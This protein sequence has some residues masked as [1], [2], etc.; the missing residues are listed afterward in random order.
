[1]REEGGR[2]DSDEP[3]SPTRAACRFASSGET[4]NLL[5]AKVVTTACRMVPAQRGV[6]IATLCLV[7]WALGQA[8]H[9][10][11]V[12]RTGERVVVATA[13]LRGLWDALRQPVDGKRM[14]SEACYG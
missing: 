14:A 12:Q 10:E 8:G 2:P 7:A 9:A 13:M 6:V 1:M 5:A 4:V 11:M 3:I